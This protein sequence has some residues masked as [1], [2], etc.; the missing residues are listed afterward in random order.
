MTLCEAVIFSGIFTYI[1]NI[2]L[3]LGSLCLAADGYKGR[4][5]PMGFIYMKSRVQIH[6]AAVLESCKE[7]QVSAKNITVNLKRHWYLTVSSN[8][9]LAKLFCNGSM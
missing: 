6:S 2:L 5:L 8:L 3:L 4:D 7:S 1:L 9:R